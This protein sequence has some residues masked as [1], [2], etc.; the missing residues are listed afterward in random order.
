[1]ERENAAN[2]H[3]SLV[4][5][6]SKIALNVNTIWRWVSK[7]YSNPREKV[8]T[9]LTDNPYGGRSADAVKDKDKQA[10]ALI[11]ADRITAKFFLESLSCVSDC[12]LVQYLGYL[13]VCAK[14]FPRMLSVS[15]KGAENV[16][17]PRAAQH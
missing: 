10:G 17:C 5:I 16:C 11:T 14:W 7:L 3:K 12:S 15:M 8:K 9:D 4:C 2:V 1:M 6:Y 13:K